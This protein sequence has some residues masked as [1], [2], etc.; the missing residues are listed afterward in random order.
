MKEH[1]GNGKSN[2]NNLDPMLHEHTAGGVLHDPKNDDFSIGGA[3]GADEKA[4]PSNRGRGETS[5]ADRGNA[6]TGPKSG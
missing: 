3:V 5:A 4:S 6:H 2:N 1:S